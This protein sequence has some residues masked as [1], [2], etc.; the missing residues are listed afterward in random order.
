M[1]LQWYARSRQI[2]GLLQRLLK[3]GSRRDLFGP[4]LLHVIFA[5]AALDS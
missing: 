4:G 5:R 3:T 1:T 2:G